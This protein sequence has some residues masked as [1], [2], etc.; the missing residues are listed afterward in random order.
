M[1]LIFIFSLLQI[2]QIEQ[3]IKELKKLGNLREKIF[4]VK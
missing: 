1:K 2:P 3:I 4:S